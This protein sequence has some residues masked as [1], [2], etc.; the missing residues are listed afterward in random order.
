MMEPNPYGHYLVW[1]E[2]RAAGLR[3]GERWRVRRSV[4]KHRG[5]P[6]WLQ[7]PGAETGKAAARRSQFTTSTSE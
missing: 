4:Q 1:Q 2:R 5:S 6:R 7:R 3:D